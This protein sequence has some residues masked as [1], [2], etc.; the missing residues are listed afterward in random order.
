[1]LLSRPVSSLPGLRTLSSSPLRRSPAG[2]PF[3]S[4]AGLARF[5]R[6][7]A[8]LLLTLSS[9]NGA[10][11]QE[12]P[13]E[14]EPK[15]Q[16]VGAGTGLLVSGDASIP[17]Q[18]GLTPAGPIVDLE[19][20]VVRLGG[21]LEVGPLGQSYT[22][23]IGETSFVMAPGSPAITS[24]AEIVPLGSAPWVVDGRLL[25]PTEL[26]ERT[27]GALLGVSFGWDSATQQLTLARP[28]VRDLPLEVSWVHLQ[29]VTTL[30]LQ[31]PEAPR[32]RVV[33]AADG[34]DVVLVGDRLVPP[35]TPPAI[36][37]PLVAGLELSS[38]RIRIRLAAG[39]AA[40]SYTLREPFRIVF[41]IFRE[42]TAAAPAPTFAPRE[43][44]RRGLRTVVIDPGHGGK[45]SG[46]IGPAGS[47]EK[48]IA[49]LLAK[50]VATRLEQQ[51][52]LKVVLTRSED[53]HLE[54][55]ERS[56]LANQYKA[57]LFLSLH[58][59]SSLGRTAH[60]AETYFL[61]LQ[62][63]DE[64]AA[65]SAAVENYVGGDVAPAGTDDF[66]LQLLLWDLAQ[67]QHLAASQ[68]LA[69]LIQ[70]ELN[71]QLDL[72]DR[73][74]KQAPFVVLMGAA[75]PAVLVEAGFISTREEEQ[76]LRTAEYRAELADALVRAVGRFKAELDG[77]ETPVAPAASGPAPPAGVAPP[78][79]AP[80]DR[81]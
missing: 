35:P 42:T 17:L 32:F 27:F 48:E 63:S 65:D 13:P 37:D 2:R 11:A 75:M 8:L 16:L 9:P 77:A 29:G 67:S 66:D 7:A 36:G 80:A 43:S 19:P 31:F 79:S 58:L 28:Q 49:L 57:D 30:V 46:A 61:S 56:A 81:R 34:Y 14:E 5:A 47:A 74:V 40:E 70:E 73:G 78:S 26:L 12:V 25:V 20:I 23:A 52:G 76:R 22:L 59:N 44:L 51:L 24:G 3:S 18:F 69:T 45:E 54:L 60:G 53:V 68:R 6:V 1:M 72:R 39:G 64:R 10:P 71:R 41:D 50:A 38:Q 4:S 62:A 15:V 21:R 33:R 55:D